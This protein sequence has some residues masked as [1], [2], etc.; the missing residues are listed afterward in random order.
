MCILLVIAMSSIALAAEDPVQ[1]NAP[2]N[3]VSAHT[4]KHIVGGRAG[5]TLHS[6]L[7]NGG[8]EWWRQKT[9]RLPD[10]EG[11][12]QV[13]RSCTLWMGCGAL[14]SFSQVARESWPHAIPHGRQWFHSGMQSVLL[15]YFNSQ[16]STSVS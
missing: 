5:N 14:P 9:T 10:G 11:G 6:V 3:N 15:A 13:W 1:P 7:G 12:Q 2:R 8:P 16:S 4:R